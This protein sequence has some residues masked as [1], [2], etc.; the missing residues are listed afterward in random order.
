MKQIAF[1]FQCGNEY[2]IDRRFR[3]DKYSSRWHKKAHDAM[4]PS[5]ASAIVE[6]VGDSM[7]HGTLVDEEMACAATSLHR[8]D[9]NDHDNEAAAFSYAND[10]VEDCNNNA[11]DDTDVDQDIT[12]ATSK[13]R[14]LR[15]A[16]H[17]FLIEPLRAIRSSGDGCGVVYQMNTSILPDVAT[18]FKSEL[19][20]S[21]DNTTDLSLHS[22]PLPARPPKGG[23][24]PNR[25]KKSL[26]KNPVRGGGQK[27]TCGFCKQGG[28]QVHHCNTL[29]KCGTR[30]TMNECNELAQ[31]ANDI[32]SYMT[33]MLPIERE[34]QIVFDSIPI[35]AS[36]VIVHKRYT[37]ANPS[38]EINGRKDFLFDC[39][40]LKTCAAIVEMPMLTKEGIVCKQVTN[41]LFNIGAVYAY[42]AGKMKHLVSQLKAIYH[43]TTINVALPN[44]AGA[45]ADQGKVPAMTMLPEVP[46]EAQKM[47]DNASED[48]NNND[49]DDDN[50]ENLTLTELGTK[51][52]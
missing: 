45:I 18:Y 16:I 1:E 51:Y 46:V 11:D 40:V 34:K 39:T 28:H 6:K 50:D 12:F 25:Y 19:S 32:S 20:M 48:N 49:D 27:K 44:F 26:E 2:L 38:T 47:P 42:K 43:M 13:S 3:E 41:T 22:K 10:A 7:Q 36:C 24:H 8:L 4:Q 31:K 15:A 14:E 9:I 5:K 17:H 37:K 33:E 52:G 35:K 21:T 29:Q 30:L 23:K